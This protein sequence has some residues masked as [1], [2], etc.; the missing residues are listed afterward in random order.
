MNERYTGQINRYD[1]PR[2]NEPI[3]DGK[4]PGT[5]RINH[6]SNLDH[7][8]SQSDSPLNLS[9]V[10]RDFVTYPDAS[11]YSRS[12]NEGYV[13]SSYYN[14]R[15]DDNGKHYYPSNQKQPD[16]NFQPPIHHKMGQSILQSNQNLYQ[17]NTNG[18]QQY[19]G[20]DID[21]IKTYNEDHISNHQ[22]HHSC[23]HENINF[24]NYTNL[25]QKQHISAYNNAALSV[26]YHPYGNHYDHSNSR[27]P[28]YLGNAMMSQGILKRGRKRVKNMFTALF[29]YCQVCADRATGFHY[30]VD[31]CEACKVSHFSS[32]VVSSSPFS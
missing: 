27:V 10:K 11:D 3:L 15:T 21:K 17:T 28:G 1:S 6:S 24:S 32:W 31:T 9:G 23:I 8:W 2:S 22:G 20:M 4:Y 7:Y 30:G 12:C 5:V 18:H 25:G 26:Q 13:N 19:T 14:N 16:Y 29:A